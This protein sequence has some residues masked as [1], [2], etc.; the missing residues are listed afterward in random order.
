MK[1]NTCPKWYKVNK[2]CFHVGLSCL[3]RSMCHHLRSSCR[4]ED[5][6]GWNLIQHPSVRK[7]VDWMF[8]FLMASLHKTV[9]YQCKLIDV[10]SLLSS[11]DVHLTL[12]SNTYHSITTTNKL[13]RFLQSCFINLVSHNT[14]GNHSIQ[15]PL[16]PVQLLPEPWGLDVLHWHLKSGKQSRLILLSKLRL[17]PSYDPVHE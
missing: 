16:S 14:L 6:K 15:T 9:L 7:S 17:H 1:H 8:R 10:D 11:V 4:P 13:K 5:T 2:L 12:W 3:T